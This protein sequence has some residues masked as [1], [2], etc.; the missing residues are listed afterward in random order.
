[1][2][3]H[4]ADFQ[5]QVELEIDMSNLGAARFASRVNK[6]IEQERGGETKAVQWLI[7]R[8]INAVAEAIR[9]FVEEALRSSRSQGRRCQAD[10]RHEP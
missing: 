4:T 8:D 9:L 7:K 3:I 6:E 5:R 1:M 10:P 2:T